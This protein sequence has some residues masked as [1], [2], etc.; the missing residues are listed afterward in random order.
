MQ[1]W[2]NL[3]A[4][5]HYLPRP[6]IVDVPTHSDNEMEMFIRDKYEKKCFMADS[7]QKSRFM[8]NSIF[9]I[10]THTH[11]NRQIDM[12]NVANRRVV[13]RIK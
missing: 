11:T 9:V 7:N 8:V 1:K 12:T 3:K 2:G 10:Y 13:E 6:D 5:A 4:N